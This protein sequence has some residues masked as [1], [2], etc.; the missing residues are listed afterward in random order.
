[1]DSI[2]EVPATYINNHTMSC[3][4]PSLPDGTILPFSVRIEVS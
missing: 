3:Q 2:I 1:M 4:I